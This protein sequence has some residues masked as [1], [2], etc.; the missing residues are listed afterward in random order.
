MQ[1]DEGGLCGSVCNC[2]CTMKHLLECSCLVG[3]G[4]VALTKQKIEFYNILY[5]LLIK[6]FM[7]S[8]YTILCSFR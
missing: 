4:W 1:V 5:R 3:M 8:L 2:V 6:H 7:D